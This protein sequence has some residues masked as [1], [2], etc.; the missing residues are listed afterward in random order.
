MFPTVSP[1]IVPIIVAVLFLAIVGYNTVVPG[2]DPYRCRALLERGRWIDPPDEEGSRAPFKHWQPDGC[3]LH[4][5]SPTDIQQ[6]MEGRDI[7]FIGDSTSRA[8]AHGLGRLVS[9]LNPPCLSISLYFTLLYI[10]VKKNTEVKSMLTLILAAE[11][12]GQG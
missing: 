12:G 8:V 2:D 9:T 4:N 11:R 5:Y 10:W 6:C 7:V 1:R 3:M